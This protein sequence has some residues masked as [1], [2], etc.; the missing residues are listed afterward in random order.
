MATDGRELSDI[1]ANI[2]DGTYPLI[3]QG[4]QD[5]LMFDG[6]SDSMQE[7]RP[8]PRPNQESKELF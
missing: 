2:D 5:P 7:R 8:R 1:R 6:W 3:R 4:L